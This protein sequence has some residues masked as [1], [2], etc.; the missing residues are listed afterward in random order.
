MKKKEHKFEKKL[1]K[2]MWEYLEGSKGRA[3]C[4]DYISKMNNI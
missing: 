2:D 3:K 1:W 4:C